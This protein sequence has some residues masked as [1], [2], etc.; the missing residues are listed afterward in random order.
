MIWVFD[1]FSCSSYRYVIYTHSQSIC[2]QNTKVGLIFD[3][4]KSI[5]YSRP[6]FQIRQNYQA[7]V[8][9]LPEPDFCRIWKKCRIP[10][11]AGAEMRYS[12]SGNLVEYC[13]HQSHKCFIT[14]PS[15][16]HLLLNT[17]LLKPLM[18]VMHWRCTSINQSINQYK[19]LT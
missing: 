7:L 13:Y 10:A 5:R 2:T 17:L 19:P 3:R 18:C 9:F 4:E 6:T 15:T 8:G 14:L 16:R 12:P 1:Y 11:G